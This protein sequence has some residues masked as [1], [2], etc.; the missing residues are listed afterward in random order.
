MS[1]EH[2][3]KQSHNVISDAAVIHY[4]T[5]TNVRKINYVHMI[6]IGQSSLTTRERI[7]SKASLGK[8]W[9]VEVDHNK[10]IHSFETP[11]AT[12]TEEFLVLD[13]APTAYAFDAID[14]SFD[15]CKASRINSVEPQRNC[16]V[17]RIPT[18][19][20]P[21][22][23]TRPFL[24]PPDLNPRSFKCAFEGNE[25][26][27]EF[28]EAPGDFGGFRGG[29]EVAFRR[30]FVNWEDPRLGWYWDPWSKK[31]RIV[32]FQTIG[33]ENGG[34]TQEISSKS[35]EYRLDVVGRTPSREPE[36][37]QGGVWASSTVWAPG[38]RR[39]VTG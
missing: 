11:N 2:D 1:V 18:S 26:V 36:G 12:K 6:D 23:A 22:R 10:K 9:L 28:V 30:V 29:R 35:V 14:A 27:F 38:G 5:Y 34:K 24:R 20:V 25:A 39:Y 13:P 8:R 21:R 16:G 7:Q 4:D 33:G 32:V 15:E 31:A 37:A 17:D 3:L 19:S